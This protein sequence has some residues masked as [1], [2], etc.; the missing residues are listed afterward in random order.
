[1][2]IIY[3][4]IDFLRLPRPKRTLLYFSWLPVIKNYY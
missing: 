4:T 2:G 3:K 1:M